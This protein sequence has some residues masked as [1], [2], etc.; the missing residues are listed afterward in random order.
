VHAFALKMLAPFQ[1]SDVNSVFI[2]LL[3]VA[4]HLIYTGFILLVTI[5]DEEKFSYT[6]L[7]SHIWLVLSYTQNF[8][9]VL[10][11]LLKGC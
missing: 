10:S 2:S 9:S 8:W 4:A 7:S 1:V 11:L 3:S 6:V 5:C